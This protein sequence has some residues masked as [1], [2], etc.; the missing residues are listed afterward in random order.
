M[1][2]RRNGKR[3]VLEVLEGRA[4]LCAYVEAG[5]DFSWTPHDSGTTGNVL[6]NDYGYHYSDPNC[7]PGSSELT[8][9]LASGPSNGTV[10]LQPDGSFIYTPSPGFVGQDSFRYTATMDGASD[11]ATVYIDVVNVDPVFA[12][13]V[14]YYEEREA[15]ADGY[16]FETG[17]V[18]GQLVAHDTYEVNPL[19]FSGAATGL[20]VRP[21]GRVV[22][23]DG[24]TLTDFFTGG[25]LHFAPT[26]T[27]TVSV[28]DGIKTVQ[29]EFILGGT[30][31]KDGKGVDWIDQ[32]EIWLKTTSGAEFA[33]ETADE[34]VTVLQ[35]VRASGEKIE[36]LILKGHAG[37]DGIEVGDHGEFLTADPRFGGMMMIGNHDVTALL[38]DVT[39]PGS[40]ISLRG[41]NSYGFA[42]TLKSTLGNGT[43]VSG[44]TFFVIGIPGTRWVIGPWN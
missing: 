23:T 7:S 21:D 41:C 1:R 29:S 6:Q 15:E 35:Q 24:R 22:V 44:F 13:T 31:T 4:L 20:E 17:E 30:K 18:L 43:T 3:P 12:E 16:L 2:G 39:G 34:L 28:T 11:E 25:E 33:P 5:D 38:R 37:P 40:H 10:E 26:L 8:A 9:S 27:M 42:K 14:Y 36:W 32:T 19:V